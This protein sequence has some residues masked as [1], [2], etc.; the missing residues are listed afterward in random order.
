MARTN[1]AAMLLVEAVEDGAERRALR[2]QLLF[3]HLE[4]TR[5]RDQWV[6]E[7]R[8]H[9]EARLVFFSRRNEQ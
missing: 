5:D 4:K 6:R 2:V 7:Y 3:L 8:G 9:S 1:F